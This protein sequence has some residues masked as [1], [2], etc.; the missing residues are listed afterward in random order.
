MERNRGVDGAG[1]ACRDALGAL[2]CGSADAGAGV[3][4]GIDSSVRLDAGTSMGDGLSLR[5][6]SFRERDGYADALVEIG[7]DPSGAPATLGESNFFLRTGGGLEVIGR[8]ADERSCSVDLRVAPGA[9]F[10]C[11][12]RFF[13]PEDS[14]T[15]VT[16]TFQPDTRRVTAP[17]PSCGGGATGLC[18]DPTDRCISGECASPCGD[19]FCT[20]PRVCSSEGRCEFE[21]SPERPDGYCRRGLCRGGTCDEGIVAECDDDRGLFCPGVG[22]CVDFACCQGIALG[23]E[24]CID[25]LTDPSTSI[26][27]ERM[28]PGCDDE[29][30]RDCLEVPHSCGC[31][32]VP[33]CEACSPAFF[34]EMHRVCP[35]C[36]S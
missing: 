23:R 13:A 28:P 15:P 8:V 32:E 6:L 24:T 19:S 33:G 35:T 10:E 27:P 14:G 25:C 30:C 7:V 26:D 36:A 31:D 2:S 17:I 1:A 4:G 12:V 21:C 16:I 11:M 3:D 34:D 22:V 29:R 5:V 18:D 9:S 20:A